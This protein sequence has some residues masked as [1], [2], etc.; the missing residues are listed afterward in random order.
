MPE[1]AEISSSPVRRMPA[2]TM[3]CALALFAAAAFGFDPKVAVTVGQKDEAFIVDATID[4][5]VPLPTAWEVLT[6]FDHMTSI[7]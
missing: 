2:V 3:F 4:V 7:L 6:D 5:A 1:I